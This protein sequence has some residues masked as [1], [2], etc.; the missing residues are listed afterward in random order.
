VRR[1]PLFAATAAWVLAGT[2]AIGQ[3]L[4]PDLAVDP[5]YLDDR[6]FV[7]DII[8]G[9]LHLR[10]SNSTPNLGEGPLFI[11]GGEGSGNTQPV[12]QRI[13]Q[14]GGGFRDREAGLFIFHPTHHH[15]HVNRW[16]Q[17]SIRSV[18]PGDGIGPILY[19]G[20]KTSFCL[21]D[22]GRYWGPEP[23]AGTIPFSPQFRTCGDDVQGISVGYH[24]LYPKY[25]P[26]QWID[27]TGITP[28]EYWLESVVDPDDQ[29]EELDET[30]NVARV[31]LVIIDG[32]LPVPD[33]IPLERGVPWSLSIVLVLAGAGALA[34]GAGQRGNART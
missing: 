21:L 5:A 15:V 11:F 16:A 34:L 26:D 24:D 3:D 32:E 22:S 14:Q 31:K 2:A 9:R 33:E 28:G 30:N 23:V 27:I 4:L 29:F 6:E 18:L 17:Y 13:F 7:T 25:L 8:P 12:F 19:K 1:I 10:L 20:G